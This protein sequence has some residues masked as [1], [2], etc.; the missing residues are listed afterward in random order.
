MNAADLVFANSSYRGFGVIVNKVDIF[1]ASTP[2]KKEETHKSYIWIHFNGIFFIYP[3]VG[4]S[5]TQ[6]SPFLPGGVSDGNWHTVHIHYYNKVGLHPNPIFIVILAFELPLWILDV[7][8]HF[9]NL[10]CFY[11]YFWCV[12]RIVSQPSSR[13][14]T[15]NWAKVF[16]STRLCGCLRVIIFIHAYSPHI[17]FNFLHVL[18]FS[19]AC[20]TLCEYERVSE[21]IYTFSFLSFFC[22][23]FLSPADSKE[24][25]CAVFLLLVCSLAHVFFFFPVCPTNHSFSLFSSCHC[26]KY[27]CK[28]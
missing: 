21:R 24:N 7:L 17:S 27:L 14:S 4:E 10:T 11:W 13:R 15:L 9:V 5:S 23:S 18:L 22:S 8:L 20:Y 2:L 25:E 26:A 6:V 12:G 1:G 3:S 16:V 28:Y 19:S